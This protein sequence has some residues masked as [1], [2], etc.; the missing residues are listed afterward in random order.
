MRADA[1]VVLRA[2]EPG[3]VEQHGHL[4]ACGV[5]G[6]EHVEVRVEAAERCRLRRNPRRSASDA[7]ASPKRYP[8]CPGV[9]T[10]LKLVLGQLAAERLVRG[11]FLEAHCGCMS[12]PSTGWILRYR[13]EGRTGAATRRSHR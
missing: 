13:G 11:E 8:R 6:Q 5:R 10:Y 1:P 7:C 4:P 9:R 3:E 12:V 2:G